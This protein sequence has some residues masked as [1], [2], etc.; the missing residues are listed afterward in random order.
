MTLA[1]EAAQRI[2][3]LT[4]EAELDARTHRATHELAGLRVECAGPMPRKADEAA[5]HTGACSELAGR[6]ELAIASYEWLRAHR[7]QS[8]LAIPATLRAANL[9]ARS[10]RLDEAASMLEDYALR[11][12]GEKNA[13]D[14]LADAVAY[15]AVLGHEARQYHDEW[16]FGRFFGHRDGNAARLL[17]ERR[18]AMCGI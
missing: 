17:R 3:Q 10:G 15:R 5:W 11:Y 6:R 7:G 9:Y 12:A 4:R 18:I 1:E 2:V 16:D 13:P 14:A 8:R